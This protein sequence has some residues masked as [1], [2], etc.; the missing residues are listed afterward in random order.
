[1]SASLRTEMPRR[2]LCAVLTAMVLAALEGCSGIA[3]RGWSEEVD[4]DDGQLL[5]IDR[6]VKFQSSHSIAGDAH[7]STDLEST[8][9]FP[10]SL[11]LATWSAPLVPILLY[12]DP[13]ANEW[14]IVA[15]TSNCDTWYLEGKP[16]PPYWEFRHQS[17]KWLRSRVSGASIGR[18]TNLFFD[19]RPSLPA[20]KISRELKAYVLGSKDYAKKYL[21]VDATVTTN[22]NY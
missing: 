4:L 3:D 7:S 9:A 20:R 21:S 13:A 14:V 16:E 2:L 22:C 5:V 17:G 11:G 15:T 6:Y 8:L 19:F 12:R 1:M 18:K 10:K